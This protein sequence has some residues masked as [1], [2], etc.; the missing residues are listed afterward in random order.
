M[1]SA[2][3]STDTLWCIFSTQNSMFL[4]VWSWNYLHVWALS[5]HFEYSE[6]WL[7]SLYIIWQTVKLNLIVHVWTDTLPQ[8]YSVSSQL[9]SVLYDH[10]FHNDWM[11]RFFISFQ[12]IYEQTI[13]SLRLTSSF[14]V[15]WPLDFS[16]AKIPIEMLYTRLR[17]TR[18]LMAVLKEDFGDC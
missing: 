5:I 12:G 1:L 13:A 10:C 3:F 9:A 18:Q 2:K 8:G 15:L 7:C 14:V 11:T 16:K 6:N 4:I 17:R